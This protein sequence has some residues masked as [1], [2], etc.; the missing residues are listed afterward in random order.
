MFLV[1]PKTDDAVAAER[2]VAVARAEDGWLG[3]SSAWGS[4]RRYGD[5]G[6]DQILAGPNGPA[7]VASKQKVDDHG[8]CLIVAAGVCRLPLHLAI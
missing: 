4:R 8:A 2:D 5:E 6:E 3:A 1:T 7:P